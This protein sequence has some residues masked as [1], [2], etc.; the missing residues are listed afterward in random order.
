MSFFVCAGEA[1]VDLVENPQGLMQPCLGGSVFNCAIALAR[2][3]VPTRYANPLSRDRFGQRFAQ[4]LAQDDVSL[5]LPEPVLEPTSLAVVSLG[6]DGQPSYGFYRTGVADRAWTVDALAPLL[7]EARGLHLGGLALV[8]DDIAR[9]TA[10]QRSVREAGGLVAV[11]ANLRPAVVADHAAYTRAVNE[12]LG[13]AHLVKVSDED[14]FHLGRAPHGASPGQALAAA[15]AL[16]AELPGTQLIALTLGAQGAWLLTRTDTLR[17]QGLS[18]GPVADTVGAGD[19]FMAG[20]LASL[21]QDG[22]LDSPEHLARAATQRQ[23]LDAALRR[24]VAAAGINVTRT[25]CQPP[26]AAE[27]RAASAQVQV[28]D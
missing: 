4:Q 2:Q 15:Q 6:A 24:A 25:G 18:L 19:C 17:A 9:Y 1:L 23:V 7:R 26:T 3:G 27:T 13:L 20:L 11:D 28:Q 5:L 14:L 12:A 16:L 10:L 8:P 22:A 21:W